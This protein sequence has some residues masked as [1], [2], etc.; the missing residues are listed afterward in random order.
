MSGHPADLVADLS[1]FGGDQPLVEGLVDGQLRLWSGSLGD[2]VVLPI[3]SAT[4][5]A[6]VARDVEGE[7]QARE[8]IRAFV[9]PG[10]ATL[11][12]SDWPASDPEERR[13]ADAGVSRVLGLE[14][15]TG[16]YQAFLKDLEAL[17]A[18][19]CSIDRVVEERPTDPVNLLR[20]FRLALA[21]GDGRRCGGPLRRAPEDGKPEQGEPEVPPDRTVRKIRSMARG[22]LASVLL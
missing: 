15:R 11:V 10:I 21:Q 3:G 5:F 14:V 4:A 12:G 17:T 1:R 20:D 8:I 18:T 13:L 7:R 9:G 2:W 19:R 22:R 6:V 16:Q